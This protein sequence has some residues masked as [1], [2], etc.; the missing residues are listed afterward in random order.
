MGKPIG[1]DL[2]QGT[3]TLPAMKLLERYPKDNPV[4]AIF[5]N[6]SMPDGEKQAKIKQAIEMVRDSPIIGECFDLATTYSAKACARLGE[7][8]DKPARQSLRAL[9]EIVLRRNW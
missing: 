4:T 2:A 3:L 7:L 9:A 1:S 8:P 6:R 5:T